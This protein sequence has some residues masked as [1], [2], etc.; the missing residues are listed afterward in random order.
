MSVA[1]LIS[2]LLYGLLGVFSRLIG[3]EFGIF[4][5]SWTRNLIIAFFILPL[6]LIFSWKRI[7]KND[8]KW[9]L[10][11]SLGDLVTMTCIFIAFNK[12]QIGISYFLFYAG[13][14]IGGYVIGY[15]FFKERISKQKFLSLIVGLI[16]LLMIYTLS[17]DQKLAPFY[18][19]A[20]IAGFSSAVWN[21]FSKKVSSSYSVSQIV[22]I[23]SILTAFMAFSLSLLFGERFFPPGLSSPWIANI[24]FA[25]NSL[26]TSYLVVYGF[27][28]IEANYGSIILLLEVFF[29]ILFSYLLF[30]EIPNF[31]ASIGGVLILFAIIVPKIGF[32]NLD[33]KNRSGKY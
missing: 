30:R 19:L 4:Y 15:L 5:Q 13:S 24:L 20:N 26:L 32:F 8:F 10:I 1:L 17:F 18:L 7:K 25:V 28:Y 31:S 11:R 29:G 16:G 23:D 21:V 9:F 3:L 27:R 14:I 6:L 22:F 2:S 12:I 33:K